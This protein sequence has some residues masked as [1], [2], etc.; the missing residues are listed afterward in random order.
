MTLDAVSSQTWK[1]LLDERGATCVSIFLPTHRAGAEIQQDPTRLKNLLRE[2]EQR[3]KNHG[4]DEEAVAALLAPAQELIDD[5]VFWR[6]QADGLALFL[7]PGFSRRFRVPLAF[8]ERVVI[9]ERFALRP[10]MPLLATSGRFYVLALSLQDVRLLEATQTGVRRIELEGVPKS[11]DEAM[12]YEE[13]DSSVQVHSS[14]SK[15]LGGRP[16]IFH[17]H[18]D[19]DEDRMNEDVLHYFQKLSKALD[20]YL[21]DREA[22]LVLA[23]VESHFPIYREANGHPT[24]LAEGVPGNPDH[25]GDQELHGKAWQVVEP[26]FLAAREE[27]LERYQELKGAGR[28]SSVIEEIVPAAHQGRIEQLF[29]AVEPERWGRFDPETAQVELREEPAQGD[30]DLLEA[31]TFHTLTHR[32]EVF[33]LDA[34]QVPDGSLAAAVLRY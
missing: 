26:H 29:V 33:G 25:L 4:L 16:A 23:A 1:E 7:A 10:L 21:T 14:S 18:G 34:D 20:P 30:E 22:P 31:A 28:S 8:T 17:G 32:G 3:L 27:A 2:A 11:F 5:H 13:Y 24:I 12:G 6:H 15:R 19:G 9:G